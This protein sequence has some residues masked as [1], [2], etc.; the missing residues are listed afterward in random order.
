M[1][2]LFRGELYRLL[3]KKSLYIYFGALAAGYFALAFIRSG[4]FKEESV[5]GD[6]LTMFSM[7]PALAGG[8]LFTAVYTDDLN[9]KNLISLAGFGLSRATIV[10][11]KF[12]LIALFGTVVFGLAPVYHCA[13]YA[14]FGRTATAGMAGVICAVSLKHLL[15][16]LAF[17]AVSGIV[18]YGF[19]RA[20]FA[21]VSYL[22]LAFGVIGSLI[23]VALNT[24]APGLTRHLI[25]GV[26]DRIL[27]DILSGGTPVLPLI[28]YTIY[29]LVAVALSVV[30][31]S[32]KEMEF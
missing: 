11:V 29:I 28:E 31:F 27:A 9:S 7:L 2:D 12:I 20:T 21:I 22:L 5:T 16:T 15:A 8:V 6:A 4:G 23:A 25:S 17:S 18:V 32:R 13:V 24:F 14:V 30:V 19:Q 10:I 3:R 26:T 1:F